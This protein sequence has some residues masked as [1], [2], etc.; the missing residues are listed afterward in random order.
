M[1]GS[2]KA[3]YAF[4]CED[5]NVPENCLVIFITDLPL[6]CAAKGEYYI[7]GQSLSSR[8]AKVRSIKL[9]KWPM[10]DKYLLSNISPIPSDIQDYA[11]RI[12]YKIMQEG[13]FLSR[14]FESYW[15]SAPK[16]KQL[17]RLL[18]TLQAWTDGS[19]KKL[20][21]ARTHGAILSKHL[22]MLDHGSASNM[23]LKTIKMEA[24]ALRACSSTL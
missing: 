23:H 12:T 6:C 2:L 8:R 5:T 22:G 9:A 21:A 14:L 13:F 3:Y 17:F 4:C 7:P 10:G 11:G 19:I 16:A 20:E 1:C 15:L 24:P 18:V